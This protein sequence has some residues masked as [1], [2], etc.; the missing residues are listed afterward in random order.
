MISIVTNE[1][2]IF[3]CLFK[4]PNLILK[5]EKNWF[6]TKTGKDLFEVLNQLYSNNVNFSVEHI[7]TL[8]NKLNSEIKP[9]TINGLTTDFKIDCFDF[10]LTELKKEFSKKNIQ[11]I[12]MDD[13]IKET[14]LKNSFD[15]DKVEKM[16]GEVYESITSIKN[17][18]TSI[19]T[20]DTLIE[21]FQNTILDRI[22]HGNRYETGCSYLDKYFDLGF[23]PEEMTTIFSD[24]GIGKTTFKMML[25][26]KRIFK[27]LPTLDVNLE[28]EKSTYVQRFASSIF[29][30]NKK[31]FYPDEDGNIDDEMLNKLD[32]IKNSVFNSPYYR[33]IREDVLDIEGLRTHARQMKLELG[34]D[35]L[36]V[37]LDVTTRLKEFNE[38]NNFAVAYEKAVKKLSGLAKSE[39]VHIV[40]IVHTNR[41]FEPKLA[42]I[43]DIDKMKPAL[44]HIK[45]SSAFEK[46]SRLV[47]GLMRKKF[48]MEK[49]F[50]DEPELEITEDIMEVTALKYNEGS[51][52]KLNYLFDGEYSKVTK[53][54]EN[55]LQKNLNF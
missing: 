6:I 32:D 44:R 36:V 27:K 22:E 47:L 33:Y 25:I 16:V 26:L 51:L 29:M 13:L 10:Y 35:S 30:K 52:F 46:D 50:Q 3:N 48:Y 1:K 15:V 7:I 21:S 40:N 20:T 23:L 42:K 12:I 39:N 55:K 37:F 14:S 4:D 41:E 38:G 45:N 2:L 24:S 9:E 43:E 8:G 28:L 31:Y 18:K 19:Y 11:K 17:K 53:H 54:T 5:I 34:L 49:Y